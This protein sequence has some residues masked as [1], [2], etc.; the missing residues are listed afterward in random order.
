MASPQKTMFGDDADTPQSTPAKTMF[1]D[2]AETPRHGATGSWEGFGEGFKEAVTAPFKGENWKSITDNPIV[3]PIRSQ[4]ETPDL[5][6]P[7]NASELASSGKL[8]S[9]YQA[10]GMV[11]NTV[12]AGTP[13]AIR[14]GSRVVPFSRIGAGISAAAPDVTEGAVRALP[15]VGKPLVEGAKQAWAGLRAGIDAF[16]GPIQGPE[17]APKGFVSPY[18]TLPY[19]KP[20]TSGRPDYGTRIPLPSG[21]EAPI[22]SF[23]KR[24][25]IPLS[26]SDAPPVG[27]PGATLPSGSI[28]GPAAPSVANPP[29]PRG[30]PPRIPLWERAGASG[31]PNAGTPDA[32]PI[33][34]ASP[35]LESGHVIGPRP[36]LMAEPNRGTVVNGPAPSAPKPVITQPDLDTLNQQLRDSLKARGVSAPDVPASVRERANTSRAKFDEN[37]K[38]NQLKK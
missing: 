31:E 19:E 11:A 3:N 4:M 34:P 33:Y 36:T 21:R 16:H 13:E 24:N 30:L 9:P 27:N 38:R 28:V 29:M 37:G 2:S 10:G 1:G 18:P 26:F 23:E 5:M 8:P 32:S 14:S 35:I 15:F 20:T 25:F 17:I 22:L 6:T 7:S 12:M